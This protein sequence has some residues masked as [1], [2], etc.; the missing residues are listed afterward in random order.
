[1][2]P[3][4]LPPLQLR[5]LRTRHARRAV[6]A[7]ELDRLL[8]PRGVDLMVTDQLESIQVRVR[9]GL[10]VLARRRTAALASLSKRRR[11]LYG[12]ISAG[13]VM[14]VLGAPGMVGFDWFAPG[15][16]L[17]MGCLSIT[18][19][20]VPLRGVQHDYTLLNCLDERYDGGVE[21]CADSSELQ[22]FAAIV[23]AEATDIGAIPPMDEAAD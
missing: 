15:G 1:M 7:P 8:S 3:L 21:H 9:A 11:G 17:A 18:A 23:L 5:A 6:L 14:A 10:D 16:L 19:A 12:F 4:A 13:L 2:P 20:L 22:A